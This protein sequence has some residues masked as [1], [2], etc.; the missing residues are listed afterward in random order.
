MPTMTDQLEHACRAASPDTLDA[1]VRRLAG[2]IARR[3]TN[4][5]CRAMA[6]ASRVR[7]ERRSV[8]A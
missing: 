8:L 7:V 6:V 1:F 4:G 2:S 3:P 5:M